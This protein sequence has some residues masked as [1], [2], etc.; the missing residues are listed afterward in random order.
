MPQASLIPGFLSS[1]HRCLALCRWRSTEPVDC[2]CIATRVGNSARAMSGSLSRTYAVMA[3][4]V[5]VML[6]AVASVLQPCAP[7]AACAGACAGPCKCTCRCCGVVAGSLPREG[8]TD[9]VEL[10]VA[11]CGAADSSCAFGEVPLVCAWEGALEDLDTAASTISARRL[12]PARRARSVG[13]RM[14]G[15]SFLSVRCLLRHCSGSAVGDIG[16]G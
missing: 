4:G 12:R 8:R 10:G 11:A 14:V 3:G 9:C 5:L 13:G 1:L 16:R 15:I 6:V 2:A 7:P